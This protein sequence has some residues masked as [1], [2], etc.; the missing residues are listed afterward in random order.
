VPRLIAELDRLQRL[1]DHASFRRYASA[2]RDI[3]VAR[4]GA[5]ARFRPSAPL[6]AGEV[7]PS[8]A[9][10]LGRLVHAGQGLPAG[11]AFDW[12]RCLDDSPRASA[13]RLAAA[14]LEALF[15]RRYEAAYPAG[16]TI[17]P[18]SGA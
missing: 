17:K 9:I 2:L 14:E 4:F 13:Y 1:Y 8:L 6:D 3:A 7:P 12:A 18:R 5:P 10:A 16:L 11:L 15:E